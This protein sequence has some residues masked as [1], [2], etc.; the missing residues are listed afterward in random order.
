MFEE[1]KQYTAQKQKKQEQ[2]TQEFVMENEQ[3]QE[4]LY[5]VQNEYKMIVDSC[6]AKEQEI[7]QLQE[8]LEQRDYEMGQ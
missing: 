6:K 1:E 3:L 4:Q 8:Q 7:E 5:K 2:Q